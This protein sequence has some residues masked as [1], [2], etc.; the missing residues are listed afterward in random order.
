MHGA[1]CPGHQNGQYRYVCNGC[2][3]VYRHGRWFDQPSISPRGFVEDGTLFKLLMEPGR[4]YTTSA[5]RG[6]LNL[7]VFFAHKG[8]IWVFVAIVFG[9]VP[10]VSLTVFR[11]I[12]S[13]TSHLTR[14]SSVAWISVVFSSI[15][16]S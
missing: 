7:P 10:V 12:S 14:R 15:Y 9:V 4:L 16:Y 3:L 13:S 5:C 11:V 6:D 2:P 1:Q 8:V